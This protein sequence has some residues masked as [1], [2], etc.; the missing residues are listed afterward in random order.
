MHCTQICV[1]RNVFN[2]T[3]L[4]Q[5]TEIFSP[6]SIAKIVMVPRTTNLVGEDSIFYNEFEALSST[7]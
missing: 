6:F 2:E 4:D 3:K 1:K 7:K 5:G